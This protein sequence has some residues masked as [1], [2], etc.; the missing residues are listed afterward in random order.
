MQLKLKRG[1]LFFLYIGMVSDGAL[2]PTSTDLSFL[3][4]SKVINFEIYPFYV[5]IS[6]G[7][8]SSFDF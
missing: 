2:F 1:I 3:F 7:I 5:F 6:F 8:L 4:H